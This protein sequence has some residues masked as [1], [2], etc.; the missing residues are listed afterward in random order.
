MTTKKLRKTF[1]YELFKL[2]NENDK[3]FYKFRNMLYQ[4]HQDGFYVYAKD[5]N[6]HIELDEDDKNYSDDIK[7]CIDC[8]PRYASRLIMAK[9]RI[10]NYDKTNHKVTWFYNNHKDDNRYEVIDDSMNFIKKLIIHIND[11]YFRTIGYYG[12][13]S[14]E[15]RKLLDRIHDELG[16][17]K[18]KNYLK[19]KRHEVLKRRLNAIKCRT[20]M[21]DSFNIYSFNKDTL[22]CEC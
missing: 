12:F 3:S 14:N 21:I 6:K 2:L 4:D 18:K 8:C 15:E 20:H 11:K 7:G 5:K 19:D 1:Q 9:N 16:N 13:Y 22:K 10:I 17:I